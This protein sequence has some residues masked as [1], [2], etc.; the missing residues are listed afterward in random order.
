MNYR[1]FQN[2]QQPLHLAALQKDAEIYR[3]LVNYGADVRALD[4]V[5]LIHQC[6]PMR[7]N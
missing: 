6:I 5:C 1:T 7:S 3:L 4:S 2:G